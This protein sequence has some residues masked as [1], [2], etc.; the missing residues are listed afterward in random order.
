MIYSINRKVDGKIR[1]FQYPFFS[2]NKNLSV[3]YGIKFNRLP[4]NTTIIKTGIGKGMT[5]CPPNSPEIKY[6][7]RISKLLL[8]QVL[9]LLIKSIKIGANH[10][11]KGNS[12]LG[13][14]SAR[15]KIPKSR[16]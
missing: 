2:F 3:K 12:H 14:W 5:S 4:I 15:N 1:V 16:V 11:D 7:I 13:D 9:F 8:I 10:D 6:V